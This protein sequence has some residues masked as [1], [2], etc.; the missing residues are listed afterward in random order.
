M[1]KRAA[2][3][4]QQRCRTT[5]EWD[6]KRKRLQSGCRRLQPHGNNRREGQSQTVI[7]RQHEVLSNTLQEGNGERWGDQ[8]ARKERGGKKPTTKEQKKSTQTEKKTTAHS[9]LILQGCNSHTDWQP[10]HSPRYITALSPAV[11]DPAPGPTPRPSVLI[12]RYEISRETSVCTL[13]LIS[14]GRGRVNSCETPVCYFSFQWPLF[15]N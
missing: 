12:R 9:P 14:A 4:I 13:K 1:K 8:K 11:V 2:T 15:P 5:T 6:R 3:E 7:T 10:G